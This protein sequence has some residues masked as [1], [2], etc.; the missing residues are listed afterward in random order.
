M[1]TTPPDFGYYMEAAKQEF[2]Q[3]VLQADNLRAQL[4]AIERRAAELHTLI[5][6]HERFEASVKS[7]GDVIDYVAPNEI[8]G[9]LPERMADL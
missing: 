2:L 1:P 3:N 7:V 5:R 4:N 6:S 8:V 9:D